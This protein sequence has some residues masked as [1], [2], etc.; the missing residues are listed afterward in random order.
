MRNLKWTPEFCFEEDPPVVP[1][2]VA[3]YDLP[4]EYMHLEVIYSMATA[5][6]QPLKVDTPTLNLTRPSVARFCVEVD[7]TK[8][9]QKSVKIGKKGRKHEQQFTFEHIPSYC[10]KCSK[11]GHKDSECRVGTPSPQSNDVEV[12]LVKKKGM[13]L[14]P[15]KSKVI[16]KGGSHKPDLKVSILQMDPL[17][18]KGVEMEVLELQAPKS[19]PAE[20]LEVPQ[21]AETLARTTP[22]AEAIDPRPNKFSVLQELDDEETD[23][24]G[25]KED[26]EEI[27]VTEEIDHAN[28]IN[29]VQLVDNPG[30]NSK[31]LND[32]T[33]SDVHG[34]QK[35]SHRVARRFPDDSF[36]FQI[37]DED[38]GVDGGGSW[39]EG[40]KD[41][42]F[43]TKNEQGN[44]IVKK[45]R[46]RKTKEEKAKELEGAELRRSHRLQ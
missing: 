14:A 34:N 12:P 20:T 44:S 7:L 25:D 29:S 22:V 16:L 1:I 26:A 18:A 10:I 8:D 42:T 23:L 13:K 9:L 5:L 31:G 45:K 35:M 11:I 28:A 3:L 41:D 2:W 4:I 37:Q 21:H 17:I 15:S 39:S 38:D 24:V 32:Q 33:I 46:G 19:Q 43:F 40:D 30:E 36:D 27:I 6:G